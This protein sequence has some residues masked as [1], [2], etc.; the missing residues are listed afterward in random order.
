[1]ANKPAN[2][3][4]CSA[5]DWLVLAG[6]CLAALALRRLP[7]G[8]GYLPAFVVLH[9]FLFCN[10]F[11]V[12]TKREILWGAGF[13]ANSLITVLG[14]KSTWHAA[15]LAQLPITAAIIVHEILQPTYHGIF[16]QALNAKKHF[17]NN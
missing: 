7:D 16:A 1:M 9:Y 2:G 13:I 6:G 10:V 12:K 15:Y 17:S 11:R 4:R 3:F 8:C 14:L 5:A